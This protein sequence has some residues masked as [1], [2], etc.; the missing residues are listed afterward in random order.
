MRPDKPERGCRSHRVVVVDDHPMVRR[1][2]TQLIREEPDLN[3][4]GEAS[5]ACEGFDVVQR[6]RPDLATIDLSLKEGEGIDLIRRIKTFDKTIRILVISIHDE[7]LYAARALKAG[8]RGYIN[9]E[10]AMSEVLTAIRRVLKGKIYLSETMRE[11]LT[12]PLTGDHHPGE[13]T[14]EDR[15]TNRE[16]AIF[17]LIGQGHSTAQIAAHL[18]LSVKT[19]E[20]HRENIKH[21]LNLDNS[22]QLTRQAVRW[23]LEQA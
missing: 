20:S 16:L 13:H 11:R 14:P 5:G 6:L 7:S 9:K 18:H 22:T 10:E 15:L 21:K 2:L 12:D 1:G 4:V 19:V 23:V 8:A 3:V 17:R